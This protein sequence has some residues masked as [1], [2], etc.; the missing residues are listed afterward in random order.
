MKRRQAGL[1]LI[2]LLVALAL[3]AL[4]GV[5][6]SAL[7]NGWLKVRE[8]LQSTTQ[9]TSVLDF[10]LAL[11]R[12]FDSPVL[13][14]VHE[15]RLPLASRWLDWQPD[16]QQLLWVAA[17]AIP[18]AEG[19]S[20]LQRQRLRFDVRQQRV[21]L[22]S[23]A[24]LYAAGAPHWVLREQLERVSAMNILYHQGGRWL[25]WPSDQPAHPGRGVRL[26]LQRDGAPY[27][28]TFVLPWGRS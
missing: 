17:A 20:R 4:L 9:E 26:E 18:E 27:V 1:T 25:A 7:V 15:Q 19:G 10:C 21:L 23:S 8:R 14:R 24:D 22:E 28:C 13:R 2:E 5:M 3:T 6:L 16:R 12:R 11:E